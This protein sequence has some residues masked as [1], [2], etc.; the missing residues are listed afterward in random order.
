M[1]VQQSLKNELAQ[2]KT[3]LQDE[4]SRHRN[5]EENFNAMKEE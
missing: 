1:Q 2:T 4:T 5:T 3:Y